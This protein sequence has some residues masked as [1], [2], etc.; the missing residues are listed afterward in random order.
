MTGPWRAA[1]PPSR[2]ERDGGAQAARCDQQRQQLGRD[3]LHLY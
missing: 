3:L 1:A 2:P